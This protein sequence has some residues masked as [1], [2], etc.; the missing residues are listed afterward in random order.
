MMSDNEFYLAIGVAD[1]AQAGI[2]ELRNQAHQRD[3]NLFEKDQRLFLFPIGD[4]LSDAFDESGIDL[5][6][7]KV[8]LSLNWINPESKAVVD[9]ELT[10]KIKQV[11][12]FN[13]TFQLFDLPTVISFIDNNSDAFNEEKASLSGE[14]ITKESSKSQ[15]QENE[16]DA[17]SENNF[18]ETSIEEIP[19]EFT[20]EPIENSSED[21][22]SQYSSE[23]DDPDAGEVYSEQDLPE[24]LEDEA[25]KKSELSDMFNDSDDE[26]DE[27]EYVSEDD[28]LLQAAIKIF[29]SKTIG[30]ELP[31]F[32][33]KT[34]DLVGSELVTANNHVD[35][36]RQQA[37]ANIYYE[38]K[39]SSDKEIAEAEKTEIA[40][41]EKTHKKN[42][43]R[44]KQNCQTKL[45]NL[46]NKEKSAYDAKKHKAGEVALKDFYSRYDAEHLDEVN[47]IITHKSQPIKQELQDSIDDENQSFN[48]YRE[49]V[50][51]AVFNHV[52]EKYDVDDIVKGYRK[53]IDSESDKLIQKVKSVETENARLK[54]QIENYKLSKQISDKTFN[55]RLQAEVIKG[56]NEGSHEYRKQVEE[57]DDQRR[58]TEEENQRLKQKNEEYQEKLDSVLDRFTKMTDQYSKYQLSSQPMPINQSQQLQMPPSESKHRTSRFSDAKGWKKYVGIAGAALVIMAL[59]SSFTAF[60]INGRQQPVQ[61]QT[62]AVAQSRDTENSA[63][64]TATEQTDKSPDTFTYTTKDGKK[65][66]VIKD[67][68]HSGHYIDDKGVTHTV[69]INNK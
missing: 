25:Y 69:L 38:L 62:S 6:P 36:A 57:A 10:K 52:T 7:E 8:R 39:D 53:V 15:Q 64:N 23:N 33:E 32:D 29:D 37:I 22:T 27:S 58:K 17:P 14:S 63:S 50:K 31:S 19:E 26:D 56:V 67:D 55:D 18:D 46:E 47:D 11:D 24:K 42:I 40:E 65:Y 16:P 68:D 30:D 41:A 4:A 12:F 35:N 44:L 49:K 61:Q 66:A 60:I 21:D 5:D 9:S 59:S 28:P 54:K 45:Q 1:A 3:V 51:Q 13:G 43:E 20:D 34:K 48:E 2:E